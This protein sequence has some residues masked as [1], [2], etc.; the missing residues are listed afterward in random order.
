MAM[1][2]GL[3]TSPWALG[4]IVLLLVGIVA[5]FASGAL[6]PHAF[7]ADIGL[8]ALCA[9]KWQDFANLVG[10]FLGERGLQRSATERK[11]GDDGF[12]LLLERGNSSY[13]VI[14]KN[15]HGQH[16]TPQSVT[17]LQRTMQHQE[18][19]GALITA[20]GPADA[21]TLDLARSRGIEVIAGHAL[22]RQIKHLLPYD[23]RDD[24]EAGA[25]RARRKRLV[26]SLAAAVLAGVA[27]WAVAT[28]LQSTPAPVVAPVP[29]PAPR[30]PAPAATTPASAA[31]MPPSATPA[32][33]MP[34]PTL[35][36][37]QHETRRAQAAMEVRSIPGIDDASWSTKSTLV[38]GLPSSTGAV[39][40]TLIADVC[41][42]LLQYEEQ[43]FTRLQ[44]EVASGVADQPPTVRWRQCR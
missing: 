9:M 13:L 24:A 15:A 43:R 35:S 10:S 40:D 37:A 19:E 5:V 39:P 32:V 6:R 38:I 30:E 44:L 17:E 8:A 23:V 41:R 12:D 16:V 36:E 21:A 22:W 33:R 7:E 29:R 34:D 20:C 25:L 26:L 4:V 2:A 18:A 3:L 31:I 14:C 1:I 28:W 11:L 27:T 42:V